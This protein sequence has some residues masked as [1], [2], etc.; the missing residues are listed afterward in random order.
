MLLIITNIPTPYRTAFFNILNNALLSVNSKLHVFYCAKSEP[1]RYWKFI[2]TENNYDYTFLDGSHISLKGVHIHL[3]L[4]LVRSIEK[5]K[6]TWILLSG[7]WNAPATL[8][9]LAFRKK[10]NVPIL[11]WSEGHFDAEVRK[12]KIIN[13]CR[14]LVFSKIN[15]YLVPNGKSKEY[16]LS[17]NEKAQFGLLPNT[18]D[19]EFFSVDKDKLLVREKL[20]IPYDKK[21]I[22][23]ISSLDHRKGVLDFFEA[24]KELNSPEIY[25][26]Q[27]GFGEYFELLKKEVENNNIKN[28]ILTGQLDKNGVKDYLIAADIFALPTRLDPNPLTVIEAAFMKK[29]LLVSSKAGNVDELV[30]DNVNGWIIPSIDKEKILVFLKIIENKTLDE[31]NEMGWK[32]FEIATKGFTRSKAANNVVSFLKLLEANENI[33]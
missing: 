21:V 31:V 16:I 7:S 27:I 12:N 17:Y 4:N 14:K 18:I 19:E 13:F 30:K 33:N 9:T 23:L 32:S 8:I 15:N 3:N 26:V 28:Y 5:I 10:I 20:N 6:P 22:V 1:G 29:A 2:E 25:V 11:F 24:F